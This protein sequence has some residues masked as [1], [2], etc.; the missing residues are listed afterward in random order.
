LL[1]HAADTQAALALV[2]LALLPAAAVSAVESVFQGL[3][4]MHVIAY[5]QA[6]A[7]ALQGALCVVLLWT[8]HGIVA[9]AWA[10]LASQLALAAIESI[11]ARGLH[12]WQEW[13][14]DSLRSEMK[15]ALDLA[16]HSFDFYLTS[17][18][19]ILYS[20]LDVLI[21]SQIA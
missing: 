3:E 7:T 19:Q 10:L 1:R 9:V 6:A 8:G 17:L 12:L 4:Q 18:S 2:A 13:R 5:A 11:G 14:F 20:R 16:V 21:L 15:A